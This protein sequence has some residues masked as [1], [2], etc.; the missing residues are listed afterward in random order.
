MGTATVPRFPFFALLTLSI[1]IFLSV[2]IEMLPTGLLPDMSQELGV[3]EAQIGLTVSFF[4]LTVVLTS[5]GLTAITRRVPRH[6]LV[7]TVLIVLA[8][9]T[10]ITALAPNYPVLVAS[11][12]L[13][14]L[15]HGVFWSVVGAYSA[16]LVP[17]AQLGRAVSITLGGGSL[18]FVLGVPLGTALGNAVG[19]RVSFVILGVLTLVGAAFVYRFLPKVDHLGTAS[20]GP[21]S[22]GPASVD[23]ESNV[24]TS[25]VGTPTGGIDILTDEAIASHVPRRDQSVMAVVFICL[26]TAVTM[27][28]QYSFYTFIAPF[29]IRSIGL[30]A[31][32]VS[33][34][35]FLYGVAGAFSL[36][37]VAVFLGKRPR[38]GTM[39]S[40]IVLLAIAA[41]MAFLPSVQALSLTTFVVWGLAINVL[42][43]LLQTRLLHAASPRIRDAASAFYTTAF[44]IGIGGGALVGSLVLGIA[45]LGALPLIFGALLIVAIALALISELVV[46]HRPSRRVLQH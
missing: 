23:A 11:R 40:L 15:A 8:A 24:G 4:A 22:I 30:D 29:L 12:V 45:G 2:T 44:N 9:S 19:W 33:P 21:A 42:P 3:S 46:R 20:I 35:L 32:L 18:A 17:K 13:G 14:G 27:M 6:A 25:V 7:V 39:A 41:V 5:F 36:V 34:A 37:L 1:A 28:G 31:P 16:Y 38:S 10:L 43:P 26:I